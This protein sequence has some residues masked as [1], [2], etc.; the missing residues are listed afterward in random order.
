FNLQLYAVSAHFR[1]NLNPSLRELLKVILEA[2]DGDEEPAIGTMAE[3]P[4]AGLYSGDLEGHHSSGGPFTEDRQ[5]P[6]DR[7]D[8]ALL[9][10]P[11]HG[12][13]PS[14]AERR[15]WNYLSQKLERR[16]ARGGPP[17]S[18]V[19]S[20]GRGLADKRL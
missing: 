18:Q 10:H 15:G 6:T 7:S 19:F 12:L 5:D 9:S 3:R 14:E 1:V 17:Y 16:P 4:V 2:R 11:N 8:E 20:L 13:W